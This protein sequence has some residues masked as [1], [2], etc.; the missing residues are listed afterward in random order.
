MMTIEQI[1]KVCH[2]A[3][4]ALCQTLGDD[5]Q[6]AWEDAPDWQIESCMNGVVFH[7]TTDDAGDSASHETWMAERV[8]A[9]WKYGPVKDE[10]KKE[11]PCLVPFVELPKDQQVKDTIFASI[12]RALAPLAKA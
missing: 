6:V 5:S 11:H 4:K 12:V 3:N 10:K 7:L 8:K 9:G 2:E 1:A